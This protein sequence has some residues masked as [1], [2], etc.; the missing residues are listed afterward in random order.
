MYKE[1]IQELKDL[2][3]RGASKERLTAA[4]ESLKQI[5]ANV[6]KESLQF[7]KVHEMEYYENIGKSCK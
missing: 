1:Q 6:K 7:L 4:A 5:K 2:K 3:S